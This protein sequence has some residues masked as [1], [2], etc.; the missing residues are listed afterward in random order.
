MSLFRRSVAILVGLLLLFSVGI[1]AIEVHQTR[2]SVA[3]RQQSD[4]DNLA[5]ALSLSLVPF[6]EIGDWTSAETL[7]RAVADGGAVRRLELEAVGRD[8]PLVID[9]AGTSH[10][11]GWFQQI[12]AL[13]NAS[14]QREISGGW[15]ALGSIQVQ[16]DSAGAY[17][18]LWSLAIQLITWLAAGMVLV[19]VLC[20]FGVKL[21]LGPLNRL[22]RRIGEMQSDGFDEPLPPS[23][24]KELAGIT[25]AVNHLGMR[26]NQ[27][28]DQQAEQVVRLQRL[29]EQDAVSQLG[30][31]AYLT[32]VLDEWLSAP[33]G[34][35][36][37]ILR[38]EQLQEIYRQD[39][40]EARD[41]V[42]RNIGTY[43]SG[44]RLDERPLASARLSAEEFALILPDADDTQRES[45]LAEILDRVDDLVEANPLSE[46]RPQ[47]T[48]AGVVL[49]E[50]GMTREGALA[51]ADSALREAIERN[52]RWVTVRAEDVG[53]ARGRQE[54]RLVIEKAL[55]ER[56]L[57]FAAQPV[58]L[59]S[60]E[61]LHRE[62]YVR[63]NEGETQHMAYAFLPVVNHFHMGARLDTAVLDW[64]AEHVSALDGRVAVNL[65]ADSF[66]SA[67]SSRALT[68][69]LESHPRL[70]SRLDLEV[71]EEVALDHLESVQQLFRLAHRLGARGGVDRFAR[72][73]Q[74]MSYLARLR[75]AYVKIDQGFFVRDEVDT[76]FLRSLCMAAHQVEAKVIVTRV[77][78]DEQRSRVAEV[79]ADGY[80]GYLAPIAP[81]ELQ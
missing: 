14:A 4:V 73:L 74:A 9:S 33:V 2:E 80:Q 48:R 22:S 54:W 44:V 26:L 46:T 58:L 56:R 66:A 55:D 67:D 71:S 31:R 47:H 10:T 21:L 53:A 41:H 36:L 7:M 78:S 15:S 39:G 35:S 3:E 24:V 60:G 50:R 52:Q 38:I 27:Q 20:V 68:H 77:E 30:N 61:T 19:I 23:R 72:N 43:L 25:E 70:A 51:R 63:L 42:I 12:V 79:G 16:S 5:Q 28:F 64:L 1:F 18:Q 13:P 49:R 29:T 32:R 59:E 6:V 37:A 65:T 69:W 8:A 76:E 40:F 34:G 62:L 81:L 11:P 17:D 57:S 75:P 45:W